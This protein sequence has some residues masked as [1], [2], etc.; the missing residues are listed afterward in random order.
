METNL[1]NNLIHFYGCRFKTWKVNF[2]SSFKCLFHYSKSSAEAIQLKEP[3]A[4]KQDFGGT[5]FPNSNS[6]F[7]SD[8]TMIQLPGRIFVIYKLLGTMIFAILERKQYDTYLNTKKNGKEAEYHE[9][10][11]FF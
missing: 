2:Y 5:V 10:Y 4:V 3:L 7:I 11:Q 9:R 6:H 1:N 8:N